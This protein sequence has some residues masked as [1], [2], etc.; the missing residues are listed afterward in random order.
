MGVIVT[1]VVTIVLGS[2]WLIG[3]AAFVAAGNTMLD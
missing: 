3:M 2:L 1:T